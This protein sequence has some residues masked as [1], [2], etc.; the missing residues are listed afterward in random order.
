VCD[1]AAGVWCETVEMAHGRVLLAWSSYY[2][3]L[4]VGQGQGYKIIFMW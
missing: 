2:I 4:L 3:F 1:G